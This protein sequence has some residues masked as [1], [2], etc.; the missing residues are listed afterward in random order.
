MKKGQFTL[1][2]I[3]GLVLLIVLFIIIYLTL[4]SQDNQTTFTSELI[5]S[6]QARENYDFIEQ[7][8]EEKVENA[9]L[10]IGL[11]G[12]YISQKDLKVY[13]YSNVSLSIL[14]NSLDVEHFS[15]Q[16]EEYLKERIQDCFSDL[17]LDID[18]ESIEVNIAVEDEKIKGSLLGKIVLEEEEDSSY[19][20][21]EI[22]FSYGFDLERLSTTIE[23]IMEETI[24]D[25]GFCW[26]CLDNIAQE[27]GY[28]ITVDQED[29]NFI[30]VIL[31]ENVY[32][33]YNPYVMVFV[34]EA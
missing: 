17:D 33:G 26:T 12:G 6:D 28:E 15:T 5:E 9:L 19:Y 18:T 34:V 20:V 7:C 29:T 31:D 24:S 16:I 22:T 4:S 30:I 2:V 10:L 21:E 32:I 3:I 27:K 25:K 14:N 1:F 23:S 11:Y 13:N 8:S